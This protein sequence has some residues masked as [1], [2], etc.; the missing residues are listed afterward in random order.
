AALTSVPPQASVPAVEPKASLDPQSD[1]RPV[2]VLFAD[3]S[4]FTSLGERLD[5]EDV[6][7]LQNDLFKE[8]CGGIERFEGFV[9]KYVGDAVMGVF[10]AP[11]A[12]EDDPERALRAALLMRERIEALSERWA[13][14][15]GAPLALHIGVNTGHGVAG[16]IGSGVGAAYAV[17]GDA[18]NTA[19]RLQSTAESGQILASRSTYALTQ[20][21]FDFEALGEVRLKGKTEPVPIYRVVA[22]LSVP[23]PARG[24]HVAGREAPF[25]GRDDELR[26][27]V[28]A[29]HR[30]LAGETQ[31]VALL[32][33]AGSGKSRLLS[34]FFAHLEQDGHL[35]DTVVRRAV[36]S[37]VGERTYGVPAALLRDA[38]GATPE[39]TP[40]VAREKFVAGLQ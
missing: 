11:V 9:E 26:E 19:A 32:G 37:S 14:R 35:G 28:T 27:L 2:T 24:L 25:V 33:E 21:V 31:V 3:L 29:F 17:T 5:P 34:E 36:C 30:M 23:R 8:R 12:H 40:A 38:Y 1:R 10:G 7:A 13:R 39:D 15:I 6:R 4:G 16:Q 20:H 18:V 22:A